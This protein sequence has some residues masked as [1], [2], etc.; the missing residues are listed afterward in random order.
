VVPISDQ[1]AVNKEMFFVGALVAHNSTDPYP[2]GWS[3]VTEDFELYHVCRHETYT[4]T[5]FPITF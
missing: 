5:V 1:D 2:A 3:I 4:D